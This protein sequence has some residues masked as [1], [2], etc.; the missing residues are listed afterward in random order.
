M[1]AR[2]Q[3][4]LMGGLLERDD[5]LAVL[6]DA[7][8]SAG[9]GSGAVVLVHGEPG[10]GKSSLVRRYLQQLSA[11]TRTFVGA[12]DDLI[13]PRA[14]GPLRDAV[15]WRGGPLAD[16]LA[17][18]ADRDGVFGAV[19]EELSHPRDVTVLLVED[20][21]WA[22]DATLDLLQYVVRRIQSL[23]AVVVLTYRD[24]GLWH[25][26]PL[27]ALLGTVPASAVCRVPVPRLSAAAVETLA[28]GSGVDAAWVHRVTAGNA[29][30]VTEML[31]AGDAMPANVVD[32]VLARTR[33]LDEA[34]QTALEQLSVVPTGVDH[35]MV[36]RL[37]GGLEV[38]AEAESRG[39]LH[40]DRER[41]AFR[42]ELARRAIEQSL[43]YARRVALNREVVA[44]L[45]D[46]PDAD[47]ARLVH[48]AVEAGDIDVIVTR[49]PAAAHEAARAGAHREALSH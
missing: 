49:T 40:V 42:H 8:A 22:D 37:V 46:R 47:L 26:H 34:S 29:F 41:V 35:R 43:P 48:H 4:S 28:D 31:A 33:Q 5:Q 12:C 27:R 2:C 15:R 6:A 30:F 14:L 10:V 13:T 23:R 44:A 39:M 16:A 7:T 18:G 20:V 38:L 25:E 9:S 11:D 1:T 32:A 17:S 3:H 24:A 19:V 36:E 45:L 21:H